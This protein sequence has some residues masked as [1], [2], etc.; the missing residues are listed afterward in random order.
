MQLPAG[1]A[2]VSC[3][4]SSTTGPKLHGNH[5]LKWGTDIRRAQNRRLPSDRK[6]NGNFTFAPTVTGSADV[7]GSGIGAATFLLGLPSLFERFVLAATD[8][9]DMQWRMFYFA[10]DTWRITPKLTLSLGLRWDT[11]FPNQSVNAGQGSRYDVVTNSVIIAGAGPNSKSANVKTQWMNFSPRLRDRV[12]TYSQDRDSHRL[13]TQLLPGDLR[14]HVQQHCEQLS[15]ADHA[16][17]SAA[18]PVHAG[19]HA[20]QGPPSPVV[21]AIPSNGVLPLPDRVGATYRP[22]DLIL[23]RRFVELLHRA[24]DRQRHDGNGDQR[25]QWRASSAD[26]LADESGDPGAGT[27]NP[28]RPLFNKF[29]LTQGINDASNKGSNS[30][31]ALQTKLTKRFS[32]GVSLL[33]T[34]TWSKT[35]DTVDYYLINALNWR[36][37]PPRTTTCGHE[38]RL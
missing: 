13:G 15:D 25:R 11:W 30:Y 9:E 23:L 28:R 4:S 6:R 37:P 27:A 29:G 34:Y 14:Q 12:S 5:T 19:V 3:F 35:I 22:A 31:Q 2:G 7:P 38:M 16:D 8:M 17:H 18:E 36:W 26:R 10:Q 33:G 21:P 1:P 20:R 24:S 32:Q